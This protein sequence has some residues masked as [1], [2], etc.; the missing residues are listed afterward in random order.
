MEYPDSLSNLMHV[1]LG[2]GCLYEDITNL[3]SD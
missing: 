3:P 2:H 1:L